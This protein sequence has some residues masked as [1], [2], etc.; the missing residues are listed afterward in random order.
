MTLHKFVSPT[1]AAE[2]TGALDPARI[3]AHVAIIMD[4]NGRWAEQRGLAR[5]AGHRAGIEAVRRTIEGCRECGVRIL[6]LYA[7]S[8]E[9]WQR[10]AEEVE[11]LMQLLEESVQEEADELIRNRIQLRVIGDLQTLDATLRQQVERVI[12][13]TRSN[14]ELVLNL[15]YNYGGRAE[16]VQAVQRLV[17]DVLAGATHAA[18]IDES[19]ISRYL[20][21]AGFPDPDLLIRTGREQRISNFL[22]WQIAYTELYFCEVY[23]PDFAKEHLFEAIGAYQTRRRRFGGVEGT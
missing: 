12:G 20:Y 14:Q 16:I 18:S 2:A 9:N 4:G 15:A 6:T 22:L 5:S 10:P 7:F 21:T 3:P 13:L 11:T 8:T 1:P 17:R 19:L 23:W